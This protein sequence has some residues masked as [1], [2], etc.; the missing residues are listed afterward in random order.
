MLDHVDAEVAVRPVAVA[1]LA[2]SLGKVEY[3]GDW[4]EIVLTRQRDERLA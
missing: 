4:E 3:D 1:L 2:D